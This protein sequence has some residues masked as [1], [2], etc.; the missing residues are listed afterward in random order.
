MDR[1]FEKTTERMEKALDALER[2]FSTIRAAEQT[3][4]FSTML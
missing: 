1:V 4:M 3:R 2:D